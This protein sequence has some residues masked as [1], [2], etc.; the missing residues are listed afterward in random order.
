M[1]LSIVLLNWN[2]TEDT[3]HCI[4]S[5]QNWQSLKIDIWVVDNNSQNST[6]NQI[7][8]ECP[9]AHLLRSPIN[10]G[11]AGGNNYGIKAALEARPNVPILLLNND[12][13]LTE[14]TALK[15]IETLTT[16][17][18]YGCVGPLLVSPP[19]TEA[20]ISAGGKDIAHCINTHFLK[21]PVS[22]PIYEVAYVPGTVALLRAEIFTNVGLLDEDYFFSGEMADLCERARQ[23][24]YYSIIDAYTRATHNLERSSE[25]RKTLHQYYILRNRFLFIQKFK[26]NQKLKLYSFWSLYGLAEATKAIIRG[27][28][29]QARAIYL[30]VQDGLV[31]RFGGQNKRV[32]MAP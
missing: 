13:S 22:T 3:I 30:G 2:A 5:M 26:Q 27:E 1:D 9:Q 10:L 14:M 18:D 23:K 32:L 15:M 24:G 7:T 6:A 8:Q 19:P 21:P 25:I 28:M 12:A 16:R 11:F 31:G 29:K 4:Q 17:S 20:L